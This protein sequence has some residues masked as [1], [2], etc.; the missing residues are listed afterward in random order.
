MKG[1][2]LKSLCDKYNLGNA[3]KEIDLINGLSAI[4]EEFN[5][6][7]DVKQLIRLETKYKKVIEE[8]YKKRLKELW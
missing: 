7:Q 1:Q 5:N 6:C 2:S 3:G 4:Q 8:I